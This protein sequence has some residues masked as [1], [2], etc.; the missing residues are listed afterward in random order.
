MRI[1]ELARRTGATRRALLYYESHGLLPSRRTTNGYREYDEHAVQR[2][3]NIRRLL[4]VG[5]TAEEIVGFGFLPC[6][7]S[8]LHAACS[9]SA[10]AIARKLSAVQSTLEELTVTRDRLIALLDSATGHSVAR[11]LRP[12]G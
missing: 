3:D 7:E 8:D 6:L 5:F 2:V 10:P 1:G 11:P 9:A 12:A 4:S